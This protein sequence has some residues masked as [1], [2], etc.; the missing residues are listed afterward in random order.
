[1]AVVLAVA[2]A[3]SSDSKEGPDDGSSGGL[4]CEGP[5]VDC[6][7]AFSGDYAGRFDGA[8]TGTLMLYVNVIGGIDGAAQGKELGSPAITGQVN[9][10]GKIEFS[11]TDGAHFTGQFKVDHS[12]SGTWKGAPGSGTFEGGVIGQ[13]GGGG[14][15]GGSNPGG[16]GSSSGTLLAEARAACEATLQCESAPPDCSAVEVAPPGCE[17]KEHALYQCA[18][19]AQCTFMTTCKS[20]QDSLIQC[21]LNG[22]QPDPDPDPDPGTGYQP[23]GNKTYDQATVICSACQPQAT[24]C[25]D[26]P[27]CWD[28][29]MCADACPVGDTT[30][31]DNCWDANP[32]GRDLWFDAVWCKTN[33]C[34]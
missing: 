24:A 25:H 21:L 11:T 30:C 33:E 14:S 12:F 3:C 9:E 28:Y 20:Q 1:M 5:A 18:K 10:F 23:S 22:S 29:A 27:D 6:R 19:G 31:D 13:T 26:S 17:T 32:S 16:G 4:P 7:L 2:S 34:L 8:D 15:G